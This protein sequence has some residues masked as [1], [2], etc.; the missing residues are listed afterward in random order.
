MPVL[1][2]MYH[3]SM[4]KEAIKSGSF[5]WCELGTTDPILPL[6]ARAATF[7][8]QKIM[9]SGSPTGDNPQMK[10]M[11]Y[12]MPIMITVFAFF[13][14]AALALYW[15]VGNGFMVIQTIFIRKAMM[16]KANKGETRK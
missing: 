2:A 5:L 7:A 6:I 16:K 15:V 14:P 13:F 9:M 12:L 1:I 3:A 8:Q 4:R 10:V 11:L